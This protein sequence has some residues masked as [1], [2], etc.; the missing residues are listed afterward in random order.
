VGSYTWA[1][2]WQIE[3]LRAFKEERAKLANADQFYVLLLDIPW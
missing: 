2:F 1:F 3:N